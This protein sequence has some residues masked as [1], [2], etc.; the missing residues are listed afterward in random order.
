SVANASTIARTTNGGT[1]WTFASIAGIG[2][3]AVTNLAIDPRDSNRV[4]ATIA[5]MT[6]SSVFRST[7]GGASWSAAA[8]GLPSF[9]TQVIRVDPTD[10]TTLYAGTD[11]GVYRSTD[12]GDQWSR[13]GTGLPAVGVDDL[14]ILDD[15][16]ALR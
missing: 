6:G 16:S 7:N 15:S 9:S 10:S 13:F 1:T 14:Q 12:S 11:V 5:G 2:N 4:W 8:T 3:R